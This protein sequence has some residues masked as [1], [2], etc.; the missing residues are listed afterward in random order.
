MVTI[1]W[2][3][4]ANIVKVTVNG[5]PVTGLLDTESQTSSISYLISERE[6]SFG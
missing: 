2:I 4:E 3:G 5:I 6:T 1:L